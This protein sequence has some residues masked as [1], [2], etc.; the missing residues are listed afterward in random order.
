[1]TIP[2]TANEITYGGDNVTVSFGIPFAFNTAADIK[3]FVTDTTTGAV[4]P[5]TSGFSVVGTQV[6]FVAAPTSTTQMTILDDPALTQPTD[7]QS[8]DAFPAESHEQALDRVTRLCK[9]LHQQ[10]LRT[11]RFPDG[12]VISDGTVSSTVNRRGKYLFFNVSTGAL[13]YAV[14]VIG[15]T[16]SQ[17]IIS[18]FLT[19]QTGAEILAGALPVNFLFPPKHPER[20]A[21]NSIPGTTPMAAAFQAAVNVAKK[22]GGVVTCD[23]GPYM[24]DTPLDLTNPIGSQN[25]AIAIIGRGRFKAPTNTLGTTATPSLIIKH[26]GHAFDT[27]G[28]QGVHFENLS[29]AT[30]DVT[31][32][33]T[34]FLL[35]RNTDGASRTDRIINCYVYGRFSKTILYNYGAE[36]GVYLGNQLYNISSDSD[37]SV[38]DIG[39]LNPRTLTSTFTTIASGLQ[40]CLD[41]KIFG[42]EY[43]NLFQGS[44]A[45]ADTFRFAGARSVKIYGIWIDTTS[46]D[47]ATKGRSLFYVDGSSQG[48]GPVLLSGIDGEA[49]LHPADYGVFFSNNAQ[50]HANW[51][52]EGCIFPNTTAMV[53]GGSGATFTQWTWLNNTNSSTGGGI[54]ITLTAPC[55]ID[56][57]SGGVSSNL[58]SNDTWGTNQGVSV[59]G[60]ANV[61]LTDTT[62]GAGVKKW[63]MR[64][65]SGSWIVTRCNDAGAATSDRLTVTDAGMGFNGATSITKPTVTGSRGGNAALASLLTAFASYGLIIDSS[66]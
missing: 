29:I 26:T 44:G 4:T 8:L 43:A 12:D 53:G 23:S 10:W 13:E 5:L 46:K 49:S 6:V 32:P 3:V 20:Y 1:M 37:T 33:K 17:S 60:E 59:S 65:S 34:C 27:T 7:Y 45:S 47:G 54:A 16:L 2:S 39:S 18:Q 58:I 52:I 56:N 64:N 22:E 38:F 24:L 61:T 30:D 48:T 9:R 63:R 28:S 19:P 51:L 15:Q 35:A 50:V 14:S 42:G 31:Y 11:L 55:L 40:S 62:Q 36:D 57:T 25:C 66:S 21:V 41:H